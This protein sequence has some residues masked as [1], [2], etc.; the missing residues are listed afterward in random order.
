MFAKNWQLGLRIG[1]LLP[2]RS[3]PSK[4][5]ESA[6]H[7]LYYNDPSTWPNTRWLGTPILKCPLDMWIYQEILW[8][9]RPDLIIETG[10][11]NGGSALFLATVSGGEP[12]N[13]VW[14]AFTDRFDA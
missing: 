12:V 7:Q 13:L 6:F 9:T 1:K 5:T 10:T 8:E 2:A 14:L 11:C 3:I 4:F